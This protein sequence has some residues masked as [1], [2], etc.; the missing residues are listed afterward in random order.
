MAF[1]PDSALAY[2]T[3]AH[4][5]GRLAHA[6]LIT[7][8]ESSVREDFA[9]KLLQ[10]VNQSDR[11]TLE[12]F[13]NE[14]VRLVSPESKSRAITVDQMREL[15]RSLYL[16]GVDRGKVKAGVVIDADR[17]ATAAVNSFLKTLEEP[18]DGCL[19]LLLTRFPEQLLD[20]VRSR[21]ISVALAPE[22]GT[23][24]QFTTA[25]Q[26]LIE[27]LSAHFSGEL[28]IGRALS[29]MKQFAALLA[30]VKSEISD[31][32]EKEAKA[33]IVRYKQTTDGDWLKNREA[34][35]KA[36]TEA[37]YLQQRD[38]QMEILLLW[39]GDM[40][41]LQAGW[42]KIDLIDYRPALTAAAQ[43]IPSSELHKRLRAAD[44]LRENLR[45]NVN[46]TLALEV[47]FLNAF[48]PLQAG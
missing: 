42:P 17:M 34:H 13:Q 32:M 7:S 40:L 23:T 15:E 5:Q 30:A 39:L 2:L 19:L 47:A 37:R 27:A 9:V 45:T 46:E 25:Q 48:G 31:E 21:C 4:A 36:L 22:P 11:E 20:T 6:Y 33:E 18:P 16:G 38:Q 28:T 43:R 29:L 41:R 12:D 24:R 8:H 44:A 10:T 3:R 1:F 14:G 35:F 26:G